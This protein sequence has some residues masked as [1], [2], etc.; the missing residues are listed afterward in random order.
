MITGHT[1]DTVA[2]MRE[3]DLSYDEAL[4]RVSEGRPCNMPNS[5]FVEQLKIWKVCE[6][7]IFNKDGK[8]ELAYV[9]CKTRVAEGS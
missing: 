6:F 2:G 8:E 1:T 7:D 9:Q 5:E 4:Q 3:Y